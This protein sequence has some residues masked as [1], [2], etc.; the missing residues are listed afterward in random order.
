[1]IIPFPWKRNVCSV[2]GLHAFVSQIE[3]FPLIV[4]E[5]GYIHR[6]HNY[7]LFENTLLHAN[8][9]LVVCLKKDFYRPIY[10]NFN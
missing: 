3:R 5:I 6:M 10:I 4:L 2:L 8:M 1:M 9:Q 7:G